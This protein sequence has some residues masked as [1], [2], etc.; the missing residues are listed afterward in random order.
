MVSQTKD[1][2]FFLLLGGGKTQKKEGD[3]LFKPCPK[4]TQVSTKKRGFLVSTISYS[5]TAK[6]HIWNNRD[7]SSAM[8]R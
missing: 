7:P 8:V 6:G 3:W 4:E 1:L 2:S 5:P